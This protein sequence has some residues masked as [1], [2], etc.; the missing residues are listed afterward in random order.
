MNS[1]FLLPKALIK[2]LT[3]YFLRVT[4]KFIYFYLHTQI[5]HIITQIGLY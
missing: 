3:L 4:F 2:C 5:F 1:W